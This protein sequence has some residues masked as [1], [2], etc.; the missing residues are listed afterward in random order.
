MSHGD[1]LDVDGTDPFAARFDD[2]LCAV[3]D[4][5]IAAFVDGGDVACVEEAFLVQR[6]AAFAAE[7]GARNRRPLDLEPA[8]GAP[9]MWKPVAPVVGEFEFETANKPALASAC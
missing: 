9:V 1:V 2:V 8:K 7:I 3:G 4:L 5:H 6:F